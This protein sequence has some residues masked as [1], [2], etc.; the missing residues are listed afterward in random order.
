MNFMEILSRSS[1]AQTWSEKNPGKVYE[2][3]L[4]GAA[5]CAGETCSLSR[6]HNKYPGEISHGMAAGRWPCACPF[7]LC[8]QHRTSLEQRHHPDGPDCLARTRSP[9]A[10]S[11]RLAYHQPDREK[12][13]ACE[14]TAC[15]RRRKPTNAATRCACSGQHHVAT[16]CPQHF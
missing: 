2:S 15:S 10:G 7:A 13:R 16:D 6:Q 11:Y 1:I 4:W 8:N 14:W 3:K 12:H 5:C 9:G